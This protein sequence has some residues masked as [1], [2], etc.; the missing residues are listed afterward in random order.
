MKNRYANDHG[1][2]FYL[3][4]CDIVLCWIMWLFVG[5]LL[6]VYRNMEYKPFYVWAS[7]GIAFFAWRAWVAWGE[8]QAAHHRLANLGEE[9]KKELSS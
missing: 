7:I 1:K 6:M 5:G 3:W 8:L 9:L 4:E 2:P